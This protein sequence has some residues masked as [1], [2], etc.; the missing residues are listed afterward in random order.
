NSGHVRLPWWTWVV[1][2]I[3]LHF[4]S[5]VAILTR[6]D[7]G[8]ADYY[9]P[10]AISIILVNIWG[11]WRT[12]PAVYINAT[13]SAYLWQAENVLLWP[14]YAFPET[15]MVFLS[16]YWFTH[17]LHGKYWLPNIRN[18]LL[19]LVFG[20]S[21]PILIDIGMLEAVQVYFGEHDLSQALP[22]ITRHIHTEFIA[23]F[24]LTQPSLVYITS[25]QPL[26]GFLSRYTL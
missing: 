18:L 14:V 6:Y 1:P 3:A 11:P 12:I 2:C 19:F 7:Q 5:Q 23:S 26:R 24:G 15:L 21:L 8:V 4:G 10:T 17:R 9:L 25:T 13:L 16:W 20:I 22:Y